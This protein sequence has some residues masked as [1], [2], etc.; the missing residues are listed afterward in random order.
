MPLASG[1]TVDESKPSR[2]GRSRVAVGAALA[3][4][5]LTASG[6][7]A[8]WGRPTEGP[9][10]AASVPITTFPT[11]SAVAPPAVLLDGT[12]R[13][14]YDYEKQTIN[15]TPV[16]VHTSDNTSWWAFRSA[17]GATG[18][19]ATGTQLE[20]KNPQLA[21]T[22]AQTAVYRFVNGQWQSAPARRQLSEQ[23]CL[24][25]SGR[26][27]AGTN[28][29][30]L[31]W[32][33][34]PQPDGVLRGT[35]TGTAVTNECGF[36]GEVAIAPLVVTRN[37]DVPAGV[38]VADPAATTPSTDAGTRHVP[39]PVLEGTYRLDFDLQNQTVDGQ[40]TSLGAPVSEWWAF[41]SVCTPT[42]CAAVGSQLA[43]SNQQEAT[44]TTSVVRFTE[45]QW[46]GTP[47]LQSPMDCET[48]GKQGQ[49]DETRLWTWD[50]QTDGTLRGIQIATVLSNECGSQG[51]VY[52][53][54]FVATRLG[55]VATSVIVADPALF[56]AATH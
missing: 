32:S 11:G 46:R 44:E 24:D 22:P 19:V 37:G 10:G 27:A 13:F 18:C 12:Y 6:V 39:G 29:V 54:P 48:A 3:A 34:Q 35:K 4:L 14:A 5:I 47:T 52:R 50:P 23:R 38:A 33:L 31:T 51:R 36:Q 26:V 30:M 17:C 21:R 25:A 7:V 8:H 15:G 20:T 28:T 45:G 43:D 42:G 40:Q 55:L 49:E 1:E 2:R 56:V 16:V 53:T 9:A 41:R